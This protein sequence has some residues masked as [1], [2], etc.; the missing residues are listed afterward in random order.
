[1]TGDL[2]LVKSQYQSLITSSLSSAQSALFQ[3]SIISAGHAYPG[4]LSFCFSQGLTRN[5]EHVNDLLL[6]AACD[7]GSV[8]VFKVLLDNGFDVNQF[9]EQ[10]GSALV[11]ACQAGNVELVRF[12]LEQGADPNCGF[13]SGDYEALVW[14]T[15]G[16]NAKLNV[17]SLLIDGG[18]MVKGTGAL[19]AAAEHGNLAAV[20]LLL[21]NADVDLEEVE[22]YGGYYD[23]NKQANLGTAFYTAAKEGH[24]DIIDVLLGRGANVHF[25]TQKGRS[26]ADIAEENGHEDIAKKLRQLERN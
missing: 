16:P 5:P 19:I 12:L 3:M 8:E 22:E 25:K 7:S 18:V 11:T 15:V 21:E 23:K 6:Y 24:A 1:M 2:P 26:A 10:S 13:A 9:L 4:I 17:V 20:E 14:A